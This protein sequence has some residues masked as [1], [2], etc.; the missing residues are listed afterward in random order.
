MDEP[1]ITCD[2]CEWP[3]IMCDD[4]EWE[5]WT[6]DLHCSDEDEKSNKPTSEIAFNRCP[7]CGS[8]DIVDTDYN[9]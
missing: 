5:G 7:D 9:D 6:A 2:D 4:C 1:T 3:T 8:L